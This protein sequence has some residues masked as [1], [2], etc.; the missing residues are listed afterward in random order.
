MSN[1]VQINNKQS[2]SNS[3]FPPKNKKAMQ[4]TETKRRPH[5]KDVMLYADCLKC[6]EDI[7]LYRLRSFVSVNSPDTDEFRP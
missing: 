3:G 6:N 1:I 4:H 5:G 7:F 2:S